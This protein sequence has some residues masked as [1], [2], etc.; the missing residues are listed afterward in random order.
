MVRIRA[1]PSNFFRVEKIMNYLKLKSNLREFRKFRTHKS[2]ASIQYR[3][4]TQTRNLSFYSATYWKV[5]DGGCMCIHR[6]CSSFAARSV[7][8]WFLAVIG[9]RGFQFTRSRDPASAEELHKS[10]CVRAKSHLLKRNLSCNPVT[11]SPYPR[12]S[13][14]RPDSPRRGTSCNIHSLRDATE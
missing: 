4:I 10:P 11:K 7:T 13:I 3:S 6:R 2:H 5:K 8:F 9:P 1:Q 14:G 12:W